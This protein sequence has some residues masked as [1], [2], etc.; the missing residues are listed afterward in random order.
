VIAHAPDGHFDLAALKQE[1]RG[2]PGLV[3]MD[4]VPQ[5]TT[6]QR[7]TWDETPWEF[8]KGYGRQDAGQYHVVAIDYGIKRNILRLL[9]GA[10][11]RW[12][13]RPRQRRTFWRSSPTACSCPTGRAIR[14]RPANTPC[15]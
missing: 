13:R 5:V 1:A 14:R 12:C 8:G 6:G 4:L 15:R 10:G 2:W 9:A 11:C 3:G 7:F